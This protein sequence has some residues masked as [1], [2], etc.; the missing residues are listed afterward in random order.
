MSEP[1]LFAVTGNPVAHSLSPEIF[2]LLFREFGRDAVYTRLAADSAQEALTTALEIGIGGLNVTSPFKEEMMSLV[3]GHDG[4]AGRIGAVNCVALGNPRTPGSESAPGPMVPDE[5]A[6]AAKARTGYNTDFIG[7]IG[8]LKS[9]GV[10]PE[11]RTALVLGTGGAARAAAYGLVSAGAAR[12]IL[13]SR[14]PEKAE[15]AARDLGCDWAAIAGIGKL[16]NDVEVCVS[17]L[18]F[19]ASRVLPI[20]PPRRGLLIVDAHY[21]SQSELPQPGD[22]SDPP[23]ALRWLFHQAIPSFEIL[24]GLDIG[25][26]VREKVWREFLARQTPSRP[27]VALVGFMGTG[28]TTT[29]GEL[30]RLTGREFVDTDETIASA[31]GLSIPEIFALRGESSFR[32][33]ERSAIEKLVSSGRRGKVISVGGGA[34]LDETNRRLLADHC[35]VVWLWAPAG[36]A[37]SRV[38]VATRPVLDPARPLESAARTLAARLPLYAAVSDLIVNASA[39]SPLDIA[40]RIKDEMDQ[41][42]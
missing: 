20:V 31:A 5:P 2:R 9:L 32:S 6:G 39:G 25:D 33:L 28:K 41:A 23:A 1:E 3:D 38:D 26:S 36:T 14:T 42:R 21:A 18:P 13:A 15:A 17:C 40:R 11:G 37:L 8:T 22:L 7:L 10:P 29:G 24:T 12:V 27:H 4:H 30:A 34:V 19:P 16:L 35:R